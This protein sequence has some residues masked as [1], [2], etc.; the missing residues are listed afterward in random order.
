MTQTLSD[1]PHEQASHSSANLFERSVE[2]KALK[3]QQLFDPQKVALKPS[4]EE[5]KGAKAFD[6]HT[7]VQDVAADV[8]ALMDEALLAHPK[9]ID[10]KSVSPQL[11]KSRRWSWLARL[12][13]ASL[14]L[15]VV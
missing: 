13:V 7:P 8:E 5:L 10:A 9:M 6:P 1:N 11:V 3:K 15:L 12:A 4:K 2:H 14:L